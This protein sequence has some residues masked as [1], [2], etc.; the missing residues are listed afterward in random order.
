MNNIIREYEDNG[1]NK[2]QRLCD[3]LGVEWDENEDIHSYYDGTVLW[4]GKT[5]LIEIKDR[6]ERYEAYDT[7]LLQNDKYENIL[8]CMENTGADG[9]YYVCFYGDTAYVTDL[10]LPEV[11][12]ISTTTMRCNR[13]TAFSDWK[14]DKEVRMIPKEITRQ[15]NI[16]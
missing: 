10:T 1:R 11:A 16:G 7:I 5:Y 2:F 9:A 3:S 6:D 13:H 15:Y 14:T 4:K 12:T 8:G